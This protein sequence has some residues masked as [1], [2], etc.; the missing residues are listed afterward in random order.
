MLRLARRSWLRRAPAR[1]IAEHSSV[2]QRYMDQ[3]PAW[4]LAFQRADDHR[5]L[6][7]KLDIFILPATLLKDAGT[8]QL[9]G[10]MLDF[11]VFVRRV[12]LNVY[13]WIGPFECSDRATQRDRLRRIEQG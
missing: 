2:R 10:P 6:I 13:V 12:E 11:A 3:Q 7:S 9:D 8:P 5:H 1:A 4:L